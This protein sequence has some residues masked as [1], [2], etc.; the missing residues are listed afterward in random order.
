[1]PVVVEMDVWWQ[2]MSSHD[3]DRNEVAQMHQRFILSLVG[4]DGRPLRQTTATAEGTLKSFTRFIVLHR[5]CIAP[6]SSS[7]PAPARAVVA[8]QY[9]YLLLPLSRWPSF[10]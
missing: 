7:I 6:S 9:D 10:W 4:L 5:Q 2:A 1:M 3:R 8:Q